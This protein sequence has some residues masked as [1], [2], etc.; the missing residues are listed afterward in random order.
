MWDLR[1]EGKFKL[2]WTQLGIDLT[3]TKQNQTETYNCTEDSLV[4]VEIGA[5]FNISSP[6]FPYGYGTNEKCHWTLIP[7]AVGFHVSI[8]FVAIDLEDIAYC[9]SDYVTVSSSADLVEYKQLTKLCTSNF[10]VI[11]RYQGS[12]YLKLDFISD[13]YSNR[14]GFNSLIRLECGGLFDG[15][16]GVISK[17]MTLGEM[18]G[19]VCEWAITVRDGYTIEISFEELSMRKESGGRCDSYIMIRNGHT[20]ESPYLGNGQYCGT[21]KPLIPQTSGNYAIVQYFT[22]T[23]SLFDNFVI[24]YQA[25]TIDCI[26]TI[27]LTDLTNTTIVESPN[28]PNVPNAHIECRWTIV[29]PY[30][31]ILKI[32]FVDQFD[33]TI[34]SPCDREYVQ[35]LDGAT[36]GAQIIGTYCNETPSTQITTSNVATIVFF[37]DVKTPK[38][39][40]RAKLSVS[41]CGG[42]YRGAS[43]QIQSPNYPG[44]GAYPSNSTCDYKIF[45]TPGTQ[46]N[47]TFLN[48]DLPSVED[49]DGYS[50]QDIY[51]CNQTDHITI[52]SLFPQDA[53]DPSDMNMD[54]IGTY[55]GN[56]VPPSFITDAHEI[57]IRFK[58]TKPNNAYTGFRLAYSFTLS[59]CNAEI[60]APAGVIMSPGYPIGRPAPRYCEWKITVPKGSRVRA[61]L[62]DFDFLSNTVSAPSWR[63]ASRSTAQR[64]SFYNDFNYASRIRILTSGD[65]PDPIY[66]SDNKLMISMWLRSNIGHRGFKL[67][68]TSNEPTICGGNLDDQEGVLNSPANGTIYACEYSRSID[69]PFIGNKNGFGTLALQMT[70][71]EKP[72]LLCSRL[73]LVPISIWFSSVMKSR[74]I[75]RKCSNDSEIQEKI[76]SPFQETRIQA[77]GMDYTIQYKIHP[78]GGIISTNTT[79]IIEQTV[80]GVGYGEISCVWQYKAMKG[81]KI[82]VII[83]VHIKKNTIILKSVLLFCFLLDFFGIYKFKM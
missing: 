29:A 25:K 64:L 14:T 8:S 16:S 66:S 32:D 57:L 13:Y 73:S 61:D 7:F 9:L 1:V 60:N 17:N 6:G 77:K 4:T 47:I 72:S 34:S 35:I 51:H 56:K 20:N 68:F 27:V 40:F 11:T 28:Y 15:P 39:G 26:Q 31:E 41:A 48:M 43:G 38:N 45:K 19:T 55:C 3:K 75:Y 33:L 70:I 18:P 59:R 80:F 49:M 12:P 2:R 37:T 36:E 44:I 63:P 83:L 71:H 81:M 79:Y 82:K 22:G 78:C 10:S 42:F 53:S 74:G 69:K 50:E 23:R 24:K 65:A 21:E 52:Y 46:F 76:A 67:N 54:E 62:V 58:T 5:P 30:G